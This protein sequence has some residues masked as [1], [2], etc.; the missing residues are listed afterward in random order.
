MEATE[1]F[2]YFLSVNA[3][4]YLLQQRLLILK[5]AIIFVVSIKKDNK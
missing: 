1:F 4:L 5:I 3:V 2:N